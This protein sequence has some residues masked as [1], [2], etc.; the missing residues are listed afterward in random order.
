MIKIKITGY[1]ELQGLEVEAQSG[2]CLQKQVVLLHTV[3]LL[4][5]LFKNYHVVLLK[6]L[7]D[8]TCFQMIS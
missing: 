7:F 6:V 3:V 4:A 2:E 5:I 8:V 1:V